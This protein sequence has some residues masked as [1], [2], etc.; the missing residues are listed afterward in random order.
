MATKEEVLSAMQEAYGREHL[1][2]QFRADPD[3]PSGSGMQAA[4]RA[5]AALG[6]EMKPRVNDEGTA[7]G[8]YRSL[9]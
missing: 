2:R 3:E 9:I 5:A 8:N 4:L 7:S 6:W 1:A